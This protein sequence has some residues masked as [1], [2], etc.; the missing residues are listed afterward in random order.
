MSELD[1]LWLG[2]IVA[3]VRQESEAS[4]SEAY[5]QCQAI[6]AGD[7]GYREARWRDL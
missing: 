3:H 5:D 4:L 1:P 6:P 2:A 7:A